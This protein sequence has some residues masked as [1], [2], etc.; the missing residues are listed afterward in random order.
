MVAKIAQ[1]VERLPEEE[2]VIGAKPI[3]GIRDAYSN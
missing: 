3:L 2:K 1:I